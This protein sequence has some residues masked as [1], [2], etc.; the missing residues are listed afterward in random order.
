M[1]FERKVRRNELKFEQKNNKIA[2]VWRTEQIH[3]YGVQQWVDMWNKNHTHKKRINGKLCNICS[4]TNKKTV[5][6]AFD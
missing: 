5:K 3:K 1:S 2:K 6:T 4:A